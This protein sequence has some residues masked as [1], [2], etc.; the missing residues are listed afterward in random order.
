[1]KKN[2]KINSDDFDFGV[3]ADFVGSE[4]GGEPEQKWKYPTIGYQSQ[5]GTIFFDKEEVPSFVGTILAIRQCKEVDV[6][7]GRNTKTYRYPIYTKRDKMEPGDDER[8]RLQALIYSD[9]G[10]YVFGGKSWTLRGA[11][12]NPKPEGR[13]EQYSDKKIPVGVWV[14]LNDYIA[15]VK[16]ETGV[17]TSPLCY[18]LAFEASDDTV[19]QGEGRNSSN[20]HPLIIKPAGTNDPDTIAM[21]EAMYISEDV[22]G[23]KGQ[24]GSESVE[25]AQDEEH[26]SIVNGANP[27]DDDEGDEIPF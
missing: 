24:W 26:D 8:T 5:S 19:R 6:V 18:K 14:R 23:W 13:N 12:V 22:K 11:F 1:M 9:G 16:K 4:V 7:E 3:G 2:T 17:V 20:V 25:D 27:N 10:L 15:K 21:L